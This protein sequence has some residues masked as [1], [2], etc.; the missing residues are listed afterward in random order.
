MKLS[1]THVSKEMTDAK[2]WRL[3]S[4]TQN[5][6]TVSKKKWAQ[7][8]LKCHQIVYKSYIKYLCINRIFHQITY[9]AW[10]AIKP[11]ETKIIMFNIYV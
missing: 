9:N 2:F 11:N 3:F 8:R 7:T 1:T 10:Y 6:L 5:H 4:Y